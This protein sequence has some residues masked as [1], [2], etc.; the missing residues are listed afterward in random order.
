MQDDADVDTYFQSSTVFGSRREGKEN[1]FGKD[2]ALVPEPG[3]ALATAGTV[4]HS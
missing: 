1:L 4:K 3:G 2:C